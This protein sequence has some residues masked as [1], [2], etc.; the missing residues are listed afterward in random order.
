MVIYV[1]KG[2]DEFSRVHW[3]NVTGKVKG[4]NVRANK[5]MT[6]LKKT[7]KLQQNPVHVTLVHMIFQHVWSVCLN[8]I[9]VEIKTKKLAWAGHVT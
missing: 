7:S 9:P 3:E 4:S 5:L 2:R 6:F 8:D 1:N